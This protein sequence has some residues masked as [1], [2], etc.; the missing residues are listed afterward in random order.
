M[1][2]KHYVLVLDRLSGDLVGRVRTRQAH[3]AV[4][5]EGERRGL[6][7][8]VPAHRACVRRGEARAHVVRLRHKRVQLL[9]LRCGLDGGVGVGGGALGGE[10]ARGAAHGV[11]EVRRGWWVGGK[12]SAVLIDSARQ[13]SR[14]PRWRACRSGFGC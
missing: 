1:V 10:R 9:A 12:G 5:A 2:L 13:T 14:P 8:M 4:V 7:D 3:N 11:D 6:A